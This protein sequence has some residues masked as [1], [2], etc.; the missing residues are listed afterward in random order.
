MTVS[1]NKL[2]PH[3]AYQ[4]G[5]LLAVLAFAQNLALQKTSSGVVRKYLSAASVTPG[6]HLGRLQAQAEIGHIPKLRARSAAYIRDEIKQINSQILDKYPLRLNPLEQSMFMLG[7]YQES[8]A[9]EKDKASLKHLLRTARGEWVRSEGERRVANALAKLQFDYAYEPYAVL[10][11][12]DRY[13]DFFIPGALESENIFIEYLGM[14]GNAKYDQDWEA[15][16]QSYA[17]HGVTENGGEKGRLIV[18]DARQTSP[19]EVQILTLL[20]KELLLTA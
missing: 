13:P 20:K 11:G 1:R 12:G 7:F 17:K 6:L 5:R 9:L 15:K 4:S 8:A 10:D 19:D 14:Q 16:I 2:H 18:I 3:P